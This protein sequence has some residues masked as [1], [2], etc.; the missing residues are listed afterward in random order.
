MIK[1]GIG[2]LMILLIFTTIATGCI[3]KNQPL[4]GLKTEEIKSITIRTGLEGLPKQRVITKYQDI[5]KVLDFVENIE[6]KKLQDQTP[7]QGWSFWI[8]FEGW[9]GQITFI[10]DVAYIN[11]VYYQMPEGT[12]RKLEKLYTESGTN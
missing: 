7:V 1:R 10:K 8:T 4:K 5:T 6:Y 12:G 3:S 11:E 2:L 9:D